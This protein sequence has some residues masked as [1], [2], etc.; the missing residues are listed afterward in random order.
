MKLWLHSHNQIFRL[1]KHSASKCKNMEEC[2]R[3]EIPNIKLISRSEITKN[4]AERISIFICCIFQEQIIFYI[5][6]ILLYFWQS[7]RMFYWETIP[8]TKIS[9]SARTC[10]KSLDMEGGRE[11][12]DP[13]RN[14]FY[15][16]LKD[17]P[18]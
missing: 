3:G 8:T 2:R 13:F 15:K 9:C 18:F 1:I 16:S 12:G 17:E 14:Y 10:H 5:K 11:R 4:K 7:K 6:N